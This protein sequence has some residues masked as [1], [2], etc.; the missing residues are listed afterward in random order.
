[1]M[2]IQKIR[3][4]NIRTRLINSSLLLKKKLLGLLRPNVIVYGNKIVLHQGIRLWILSLSSLSYLHL[5][6]NKRGWILTRRY[7]LRMMKFNIMQYLP[8]IDN[9]LKH[10]K[11]SWVTVIMI[12]PTFIRSTFFRPQGLNQTTI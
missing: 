6:V 2:L 9:E 7:Y 1:M 4:R 11:I 10:N 3:L 12:H 5:N 8:L